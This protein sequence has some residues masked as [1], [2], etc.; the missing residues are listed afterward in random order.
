MTGETGAT[1]RGLCAQSPGFQPD[2]ESSQHRPLLGMEVCVS[3]QWM[4][5]GNAAALFETTRWSVVCA[6]GAAKGEDSDAAL[7]WL[8]E[9]YWFPLYTYVRGRGHEPETAEDIVQGFFARI[10]ARDGIGAADAGRGT[11]RT[12]LLGCLNHHLADEQRRALAAKRGAGLR[13][14]SLH[15]ENAEEWLQRDIAGGRTPEQ[16]YDRAWALAVLERVIGRLRIECEADGN[17]GRFA[18]LRPFLDG[19]RGELPL[20]EAASRLRMSLAGVKSLVHRLRA[21]MR[22]MIREEIRET[23]QTESQVDDEL[24]SIFAA[25]RA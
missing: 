12:F 19:D 7:A 11:F 1:K 20:A 21:R 14:V 2:A 9:R 3:C 13:L 17:E 23:V 8:C 4:A 25:L 16:D 18:L 10:I 6:A 22:E 5:E 24:R 15:D